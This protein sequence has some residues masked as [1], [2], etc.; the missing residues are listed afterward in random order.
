MKP[1]RIDDSRWQEL[2][3]YGNNEFQRKNYLQ[4]QYYYELALDEAEALLQLCEVQTHHIPIIP[5]YVISFKNLAESAYFLELF[6]TQQSYLERLYCR[7]TQIVL[8]DEL[9]EALRESSFR[10]ISNVFYDLL[11]FL[12]DQGHSRFVI[13]SYINSHQLFVT[14]R[15]AQQA[16]NLAYSEGF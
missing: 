9:P 8:N 13:R 6:H 4:A 14:R 11:V 3:N 10:E 1:K 15:N 5:L 12:Q 16:S 7:M 2:T